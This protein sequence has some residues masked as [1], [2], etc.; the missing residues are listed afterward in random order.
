MTFETPI[1]SLH[2]TVETQGREPL[3]ARQGTDRLGELEGFV[4]E[5]GLSID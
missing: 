4:L 3:L 5:G 1:T 2:L